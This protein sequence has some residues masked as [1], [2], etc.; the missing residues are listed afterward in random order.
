MR[1]ERN[2]IDDFNAIHQALQRN[3]PK[4]P[5]IIPEALKEYAEQMGMQEGKDFIVN[6]CYTGA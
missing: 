3:A 2:P 6:K 4:Q 1:T 5:T